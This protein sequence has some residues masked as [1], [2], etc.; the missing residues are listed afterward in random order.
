VLNVAIQSQHL[1]FGKRRSVVADNVE[2]V[3]LDILKNIQASIARLDERFDHLEAA[4]R[5]DR[6]NVAGMLV[7]MRAT[8]GDFD[9]RVSEIEERVAAL[10]PTAQ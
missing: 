5:K 4:M 10:E 1:A 6:R 3:T 7:M 8:A 9:E 2:S